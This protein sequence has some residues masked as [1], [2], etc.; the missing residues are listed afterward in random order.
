MNKSLRNLKSGAQAGFTLIELVV[1]IVILGILAATAI[2]KFIDMSTQAR[3]AKMQG[4]FGAVK[5][6]AAL[7]HA[8]WLVSGSPADGNTVSMEGKA[9]AGVN[10]YPA[11]SATGIQEAAGLLA[12]DYG[13]AAGTGTPATFTIT[14]DPNTTA[15]RANCNVVYTA[16]PVGGAPTIVLN[17]SEA[18]CK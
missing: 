4:A 10:G 8:Q 2:P 14:V 5:A 12:T 17:A 3:V 7:Y 13:L 9:I 15:T 1:V 6:G 11:A 18:N 16:A